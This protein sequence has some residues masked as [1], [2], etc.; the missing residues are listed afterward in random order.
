VPINKFDWRPLVVAFSELEVSYLVTH[1]PKRSK[2]V[3]IALERCRENKL[4]RS[5]NSLKNG[6]T[7]QQWTTHNSFCCRFERSNATRATDERV[8]ALFV[9]RSTPGEDTYAKRPS[10]VRCAISFF[11][12]SFMLSKSIADLNK[13]TTCAERSMSSCDDDDPSLSGVY[14]GQNPG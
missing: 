9:T 7:N 1:I 8:Q 5:Y 12:L 10:A 3:N 6:I 14:R 13:P 4:Q 2:D 11:G